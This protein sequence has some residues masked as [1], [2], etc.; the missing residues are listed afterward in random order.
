MS[1]RVAGIDGYGRGAWVAVVLV[2]GSFS[3]ALIGRSLDQ[4][5]PRLHECSLITIDIPIGLPDVGYREADRLAAARLGPRRSSVFPT[6]P[7][8][9]LEAATHGGANEVARRILGKGVSLQTY[10]LRGRIFEAEIQVRAGVNLVE[11]HPEVCFAELA[12]APLAWS[13][14]SWRGAP[15]RRKLLLDAGIRLPDAL[16]EADGVPIADVLDASVAAWSA[17]RIA[18]GAA[19]SLPDPP[20][21][22]SDGIPAAIHA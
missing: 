17:D 10:G 4:L 15:L 18:R 11:V 1:Q 3:S 22:H 12:G 5:L 8:A 7:R 9:V 19:V 6:P 2:D 13:K 21:V 16:D 14:A 20:S